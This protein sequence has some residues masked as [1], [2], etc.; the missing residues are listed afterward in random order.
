M[1]TGAKMW[2]DQSIRGEKALDMTGRCKSLQT[3][4]ALARRSMRVR[5]AIMQIATLAVLYPWEHLAFGHA[6]A[7]SS[8]SRQAVP[9]PSTLENP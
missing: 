2:G 7:F 3:P 5:T 9:R 4:L 6:I 8:F 1:P